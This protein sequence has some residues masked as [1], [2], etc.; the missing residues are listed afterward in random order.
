MNETETQLLIVGG[1]SDPN[2]RRVVDQAHLRGIDYFFWDTDQ[3]GA[4]RIAWDF[5]SPCIDFDSRLIRPGGAF[6][7]YNVF[8]GDPARNVAVFE[9]VQS[10]LL[11]WPELLILNR[12]VMTDGNNKSR[13]LRW[14]REAGFRIPETLVMAD[15]SPLSSMP[16]P[17]DFVIKPL[18]GGAHTRAVADVRDDAATLA[19][20]GPQFVQNRLQ[21]ENLRLFA[22][23]DRQFCFHLGTKALDYRDDEWV[24]VEQVEIPQELIT[25]AQKLVQRIGF[26]YCALD[27]RCTA[28]REEPVFLEI[29][30][31]PMFVRFDDAGENCLADAILAFLVRA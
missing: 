11:A 9:T 13:N 7:R 28:D 8:E 23:G 29:N 17:E 31:F 21:G 2:T 10:Y 1:E 15:L 14:A 30:S 26:D 25:P 20:L 16:R 24:S 6:L 27:F 3:A 18:G 5:E 22:I 4:Q 19:E 12:A